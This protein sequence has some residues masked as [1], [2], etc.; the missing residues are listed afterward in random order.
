M[1]LPLVFLLIAMFSLTAFGQKYDQEVINNLK[2]IGMDSIVYYKTLEL[3]PSAPGRILPMKSN[4]AELMAEV[5][6]AKFNGFAF[7]HGKTDKPG[8]LERN[9]VVANYRAEWLKS[10]IAS[11][12]MNGVTP[13]ILSPKLNQADRG[14]E[15]IIVTA[16]S[17]KKPI[18][19]IINTSVSET[20]INY[21]N[22]K[23]EQ[24]KDDQAAFIQATLATLDQNK[25][26]SNTLSERVRFG[27]GFAGSYGSVQW[28]TY[29]PSAAISLPMFGVSYIQVRAY[30][31]GSYVG[32]S[33]VSLTADANIRLWRS[34]GFNEFYLTGGVGYSS[35]RQKDKSLD[36]FMDGS[37]YGG[38]TYNIPLGEYN[39]LGFTGAVKFVGD[40]DVQHQGSAWTNQAIQP[41]G[42]VTFWF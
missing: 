4:R 19:V 15:V 17:T 39:V 29:G 9:H 37:I 12:G 16:V 26:L 31:F 28:P 33:G 6:N 1:K 21:L 32:Q 36:K 5:L 41:F 10:F 23:L 14:A 38:V 40:L 8:S 2:S 24:L 20:Q 35:F 22:S 18:P 11:L 3:Q 13:V 42:S 7:I 25:K 34:S 27:I 30:G